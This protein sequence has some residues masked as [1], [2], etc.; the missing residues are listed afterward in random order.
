[1]EIF[2]FLSNQLLAISRITLDEIQ[3]R[4]SNPSKDNSDEDDLEWEDPQQERGAFDLFDEWN[5]CLSKFKQ[6]FVF[7]TR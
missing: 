4:Y 3:I 1:M 7:L 5:K 6:I 2:I